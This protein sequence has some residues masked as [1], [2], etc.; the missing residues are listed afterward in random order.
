METGSI[1]ERTFNSGEKLQDIF[2]DYRTMQYLYT[3]GDVYTF[4]DTETY[5]ATDPERQADRRRRS[6]FLKESM[7]VTVDYYQDKALKVTLPNVVAL[8]ITQTEPRRQG[9]YSFGR[10]ETGGVRDRR[11]G[12]RAAFHR[13]GR[14]HPGRYADRRLSGPRLNRWT[15]KS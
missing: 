15:P 1:V 14:D 8:T 12:R 6:S 3:D 4:M 10:L 2:I 11:N 13:S 9:R 7:E 5:R